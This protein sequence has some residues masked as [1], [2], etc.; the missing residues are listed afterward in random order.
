MVGVGR[1]ELPT[2]RSRTVRS[3]QAELHPAQIRVRA[4]SSK[5][6][7]ETAR[8]NTARSRPPRYRARSRSASSLTH[9][10]RAAAPSVNE[11]LSSPLRLR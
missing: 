3:S 4:Q 5:K 9:S 6:N 1:F 8:S 7:R 2:S 10:V 11:P